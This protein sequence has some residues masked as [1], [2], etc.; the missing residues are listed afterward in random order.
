MS[1]PIT[2]TNTFASQ[3]GPIPLSELDAN[4][5][6]VATAIN[7]IST[8]TNALST[9][10]LGNASAD[11]L[12]VSGPIQSASSSGIGYSAGAGS[13][14]TQ[15]TST[16]T[17]VTINTI[18]GQITM[19]NT[20]LAAAAEAT[21]TVTNSSVSSTDVIIVNHASVGTAGAYIVGISGVA[22]G[23]FKI[24]VSNVSTSSK[25]EAIVLN[26]AIIKAVNA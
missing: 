18:C 16:T 22:T 2:I 9:P 1:L 25:S 17:G 7:Q 26:Y 4:F 20:A 8:G 12:S 15:A 5:T 23:S 13:S 10:I 24:T 3:S 6:E 14:V 21:F 19:F 11:S